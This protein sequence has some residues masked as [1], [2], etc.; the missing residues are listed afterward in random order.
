MT[1][2][3]LS[4]RE[5]LKKSVLATAA[6]C[7]GSSRILG[8]NEDIRLG[9]I[10]I[11]SLGAH[12]IRTFG[13]IPGVRILALCDVDQTILDREV[14]KLAERRQKVRAYRDARKL[15]DDQEVDA[16]VVATPNH[17]HCL[18]GIWACQAGKDLYLE[19]PVSHSVWEGRKLVEA[20]RKYNRIV[21]AGTQNRSDVGFREAISYLRQ[22]HL[23]KILWAHGLWYKGR[24]SLGRVS[25]PQPIPPSVDYDLWCG[26]A[27]KAPLMR[28]SLHYDW[29]W[30]WDTGNGDMG[31]LGAHQIDD[32]RFAVGISGYPSRVISYGG[33]F[34][35]D[36]NA[37][38]PNTQIAVFDYPEHPVIVEVRNLAQDREAKHMDHYRG[39]REANVIQ[40]ENGYFG[41][42]RGGGWV[43]DNQGK[44]LRQFPGDGG[45]N[46]APNFIEAVRTRRKQDLNAEVL[47]GHI[48]AA[49]CH[50][51]NISYRLGRPVDLE[52]TAP[53]LEHPA[54]VEAHRRVMSHLALNQVDPKKP[55]LTVGPW[56]EVDAAEEK[57]RGPESARANGFLRRKKYRKPFVVPEKI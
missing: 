28:K 36:D 10:G 30:F 9:M 52:K 15:L 40:C 44:R 2:H 1:M 53:P 24:A 38:T 22:G 16:V 39:V 46:H 31:N 11:G 4:R 12:H 23:G 13:A 7:A 51:A 6:C 41:G 17:W 42:G 43:Y 50:M 37:E 56:L 49:L 48:S 32:C 14:G 54:V 8:A 34:L 27:E 21:Q 26:P 55:G 35:F 33:R 5:L 45:A 18:L 47:E 19:K 29:H 25:S 3:Q 57:F 20:A